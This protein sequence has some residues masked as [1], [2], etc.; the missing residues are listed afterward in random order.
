MKY[1]KVPGDIMTADM[2]WHKNNGTSGEDW[3][4]EGGMS[5][6]TQMIKPCTDLKLIGNE[7]FPDGT[8]KEFYQGSCNGYK[9]SM[10][11]CHC[12]DFVTVGDN[13]AGST[14]LHIHTLYFNG[15]Q[16]VTY[17]QNNRNT[18][19]V[20]LAEIDAKCIP[21]SDEPE[22]PVDN[23]KGFR[24][25]RAS[26]QSYPG[27]YDFD[28]DQRQHFD[29]NWDI[30]DGHKA[31]DRAGTTWIEETAFTFVTNLGTSSSTQTVKGYSFNECSA[32]NGVDFFDI[33]TYGSTEDD[34]CF[35]IE[36]LEKLSNGNYK[37]L[38][39]QHDYDKYTQFRKIKTTFYK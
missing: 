5:T 24:L 31:V 16:T 3:I 39:E 33:E 32:N 20:T 15:H 30:K 10:Y 25:N 8:Y 21:Q 14:G 26:T 23:G 36:N 13:Y 12:E 2:A 4:M 34:L 19:G 27:N 22:K 29:G 37:L 11:T 28:E 9:F 1:L 6:T 18:L 17:M 38:K 7:W 35:N